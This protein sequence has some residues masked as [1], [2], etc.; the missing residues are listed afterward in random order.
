MFVRKKKNRS[1]STSI[2]IV[3]KRGGRFKE[4][5]TV[6]IAN[7]DGDIAALMDKGRKWIDEY[8]GV[9]RI[10]FEG[11]DRKTAEISDAEHFLNNIDSVLRN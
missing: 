10:D 8:N 1:G 11:I 9:R 7:G 5:H 3:D 6:G 2:V 4:L